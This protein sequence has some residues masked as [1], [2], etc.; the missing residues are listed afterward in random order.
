MAWFAL[1]P[2]LPHEEDMSTLLVFLNNKMGTRWRIVTDGDE[3]GG[4]S[5]NDSSKSDDTAGSKST[6]HHHRRHSSSTGSKKKYGYLTRW[7]GFVD[8]YCPDRDTHVVSVRGT[9]LTSSLD[10]VQDINMFFEA[11]FFQVVSSVV[12]GASLLPTSL[13][14]DFIKLSSLTDTVSESSAWSFLASSLSGAPPPVLPQPHQHQSTNTHQPSLPSSGAPH[15]GSG[16]TA[17][18]LSIEREYYLQ[19]LAYVERLQQQHQRTKDSSSKKK[20]RGGKLLLTGHSLGGSIAHVVASR[21]GTRSIGFNNPG[22]V[23]AHKKFGIPDVSAI[24]RLT[25]SILATHDLVPL[26]GWQGGAMHHVECGAQMRELCHAMEFMVASLWRSCGSIRRRYPN[27][28][29]I[30]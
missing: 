6:H 30:E 18:K 16:V 2:Y 15:R 27:I 26:I 9:D 23:L 5:S 3:D 1:I 21:S 14:T 25:T 17:S 10:M 8:F 28:T 24:H 29:S 12:P 11:A 13:V 19:V 7:Q 22:V 4:S 20:G